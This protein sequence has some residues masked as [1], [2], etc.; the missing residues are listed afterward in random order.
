ML[1]HASRACRYFASDPY[2]RT[3][4]FPAWLAADKAYWQAALNASSEIWGQKVQGRIFG[5]GAGASPPHRYGVDRI[6]DDPSSDHSL[7]PAAV[8][9]YTRTRACILSRSLSTTLPFLWEAQ[10]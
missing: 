10:R 6:A 2:Y 4:L 7:L 3:Q 8:A 1:L 5:C 9:V